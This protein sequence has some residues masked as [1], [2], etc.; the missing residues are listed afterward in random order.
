MLGAALRRMVFFCGVFAGF[1]V[2]RF[3]TLFAALREVFLAGAGDFVFVRAVVFRFL[4]GFA[5]RFWEDFLDAGCLER[6]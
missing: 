3:A 5:A 6:P 1:L 2:R 4:A